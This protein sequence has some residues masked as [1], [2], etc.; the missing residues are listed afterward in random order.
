MSHVGETI[1]FSL[2]TVVS[3]GASSRCFL[4]HLSLMS[5]LTSPL[6]SYSAMYLTFAHKSPLSHSLRLLKSSVRHLLLVFFYFTCTLCM[7]RSE[8]LFS[9]YRIDFVS[10]PALLLVKPVAV[11]ASLRLSHLSLPSSFVLSRVLRCPSCRCFA[12][13]L[14]STTLYF[15]P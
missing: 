2:R 3:C 11:V 9:S 12:R 7:H 5:Y 6:L 15:V 8:L 4:R 13:H 10:S 14:L 1:A